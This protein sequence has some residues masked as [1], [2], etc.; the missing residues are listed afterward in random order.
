MNIEK[1]AH[2]N[3]NSFSFNFF[4][5]QFL[6]CYCQHEYIL[7]LFSLANLFWS[8]LLI[9]YYIQMH[10]NTKNRFYIPWHS[11]CQL[12]GKNYKEI[13]K[14]LISRIKHHVISVHIYI[15]PDLVSKENEDFLLING[16][17][18]NRFDGYR[19]IISIIRATRRAKS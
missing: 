10:L 19:T 17:I 8:Y 5:Y 14:K 7:D 11:H 1:D 16:E 12:Y 13:I 18:I 2:S 15:K 6:Y 4:I 9:C 3:F